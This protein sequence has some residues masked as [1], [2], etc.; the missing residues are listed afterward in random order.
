MT[1]NLLNNF[2]CCLR[3]HLASFLSADH[4][5]LHVSSDGWWRINHDL[6][7]SIFQ[8]SKY[9]LWNH[10]SPPP[11]KSHT[12]TKSLHHWEPFKELW[13]YT[14]L[15]RLV[16]PYLSNKTSLQSLSFSLTNLH[17]HFPTK[18]LL[19]T[20]RF[21]IPK[22]PLSIGEHT[23]SHFIQILFSHLSLLPIKTKILYYW[24]QH[25]I[26]W[27]IEKDKK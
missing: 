27:E 25:T 4:L 13:P 1:Y 9:S 22:S 17:I 7:A 15:S 3:R 16:I 12:L 21:L 18:A 2:L 23:T 19:N 14:N 24:T 5:P 10:P 11:T 26:S 6:S 20:S 8:H